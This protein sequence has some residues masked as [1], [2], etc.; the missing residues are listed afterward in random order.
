M[1]HKVLNEDWEDY[2]NKKIRGAVDSNKFS[3]DEPWEVDYLIK[4]LQKHYPYK[5]ADAIRAAV[6]ACCKIAGNRNRED[7]V[8]CVTKRLDR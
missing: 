2:D 6:E 3:C 8:D 1:P 5:T 7:F 4:K